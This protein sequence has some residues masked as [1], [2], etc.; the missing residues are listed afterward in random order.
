[1]KI[2][3]RGRSSL[4][5]FLTHSLTHTHAH[6]HTPSISNSLSLSLSLTHASLEC[7]NGRQTTRVWLPVLWLWGL[8]RV[9]GR[10]CDDRHRRVSR[11]SRRRR[12]RRSIIFPSRVRFDVAS[13][14][15]RSH[16]DFMKFDFGSFGVIGLSRC[17]GLSPWSFEPN[18]WLSGYRASG[19]IKRKSRYPSE[20]RTRSFDKTS[21][22]LSRPVEDRPGHKIGL[23]EAQKPFLYGLN[24]DWNLMDWILL[25]PSSS[26]SSLFKN[27]NNKLMPILLLVLYLN[28]K[29]KG[30][31]LKH[32][33]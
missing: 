18:R 29:P 22:D 16:S 3:Y 28:R 12:R 24:Y 25:Q 20:T 27:L 31:L 2:T 9:L 15:V 10:D 21:W 13:N 26:S 1:M 17:C 8:F 4:S 11:R 30:I 5:L 7:N 14:S 23:K 19:L 33:N 32:V 6:T